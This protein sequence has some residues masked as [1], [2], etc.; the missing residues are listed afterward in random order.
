ML[1]EGYKNRIKKLAGIKPM[2]NE[3]LH[4]QFMD[5]GF[6]DMSNGNAKILLSLLKD[7]G[8]KHT[9][10]PY[11]NYIEIETNNPREILPMFDKSEIEKISMKDA[12][13][14]ELDKD[15]ND[16]V[17]L[18]LPAPTNVPPGAMM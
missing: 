13:A 8:I 10:D 18:R 3:D 15:P 11:R 6:Y 4:P 14:Q 12:L 17:L 16:C 5:C 9:Y 1:T 7:A 2:L